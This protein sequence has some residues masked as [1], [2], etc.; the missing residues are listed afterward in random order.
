[1][2]V[3]S[4]AGGLLGL[5]IAHF[6]VKLIVAFL[7]SKLP[8][9]SGI[10]V[11]GW[12]LAFTLTVSFVAGI[13]AGL[14]PAFRLS[15]V[16]VSQAL[17]QGPRTSSD[18][19]GNRT[20]GMLVVSEVALSLMLLVGAGLLIRTLWALRKVDPGLDPHNLVAVIPSISRTTFPQAEQEIAFYQQ[21]LDKVKALPGVEST[22]AIDALPL[23]GCSTHTVHL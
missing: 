3:L 14:V 15:N 6:G 4:V 11:D 17:K 8:R 7:A 23:T 16:N 5:L 20:R 22:A 1:T 13:L 12:V 10:A 21:L 19:S 9:A 18:G 2:V